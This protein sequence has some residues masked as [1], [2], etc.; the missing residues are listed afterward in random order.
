ME[1]LAADVQNLRKGLDVAKMEKEKQPD[2]YALHVS[3]P[4]NYCV[5]TDHIYCVYF[6]CVYF[7]S[8]MF[9]G[10]DLGLSIYVT[11]YNYKLLIM[12]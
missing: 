9:L 7:F 12:S 11:N 3:F 1:T 4:R 8:Q 6:Y 2:N 5:L 10:V